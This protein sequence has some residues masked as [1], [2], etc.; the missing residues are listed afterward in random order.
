M[1]NFGSG[2]QFALQNKPSGETSGTLSSIDMYRN[3]MLHEK[4]QEELG[5]GGNSDDEDENENDGDNEGASLLS[6]MPNVKN[7][8]T[9]SGGQKNQLKCMSCAGVL[10]SSWDNEQD[11]EANEQFYCFPDRAPT[12]GSDDNKNSLDDDKQYVCSGAIR[13]S[14]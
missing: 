14:I 7:A 12:H 2:Q 3:M 6:I 1:L 5:L 11:D 8:D 9:V 13:V 10:P 4:E